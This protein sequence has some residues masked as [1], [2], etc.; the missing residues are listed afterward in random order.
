MKPLRLILALL[1][2]GVVAAPAGGATATL[3]KKEYIAQADR[4]CAV[5]AARMARV[6]VQPNESSLR[7]NGPAFLTLARRELARLWRLGPPR[8][9]RPI[10]AL[11]KRKIDAFAADVAA[12]RAG[13]FDVA[14]SQVDSIGA[15]LFQMKRR[16]GFRVC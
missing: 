9:A 7:R 12:A 3:S 11:W 8:S 5:Y 10:L 2:A 1:L 6:P 4:V 16:Y 13:T 14:D 15:R